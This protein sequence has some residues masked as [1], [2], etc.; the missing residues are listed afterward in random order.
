MSRH[1]STIR[2]LEEECNGDEG[3]SFIQSRDVMDV[4][5]WIGNQKEE[6]RTRIN[7]YDHFYTDDD[8]EH[9]ETNYTHDPGK[10]VRWGLRCIC[11]KSLYARN[12][13]FNK[14]DSV[15]DRFH[16]ATMHVWKMS[17]LFSIITA[18]IGF[19]LAHLKLTS[20]IVFAYGFLILFLILELIHIQVSVFEMRRINANPKSKKAYIR[21]SEAYR[22]HMVSSWVLLWSMSLWTVAIVLEPHYSSM[23]LLVFVDIQLVVAM[24]LHWY[25]DIGCYTDVTGLGL[26]TTFVKM[27]QLVPIAYLNYETIMRLQSY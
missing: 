3:I 23:V 10:I 12:P 26:L 11:G 15:V 17:S 7:R 16:H 8:T 1:R 27:T 25:W 14:T 5:M 19:I 13:W 24:G 18:L 21:M 6:E 20:V 4:E 22:T 9:I 2:D